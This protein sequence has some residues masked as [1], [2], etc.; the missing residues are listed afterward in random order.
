MSEVNA[1][2]LRITD[3]ATDAAKSLD[4]LASSLNKIRNALSNNLKLEQV[5][6][7]LG[8]FSTALAQS[9]SGDKVNK[10]NAI[11][12]A[13]HKLANATERLKGAGV[14]FQQAM[15][16]VDNVKANVAARVA[17]TPGVKSGGMA[18]SKPTVQSE[19][20][21]SV[22]DAAQKTREI[23]DNLKEA[24]VTAADIKIE[25]VPPKE[26]KALTDA[27]QALGRIER[28][29][30]S[31]NMTNRMYQDR[32]APLGTPENGMIGAAAALERRGFTPKSTPSQAPQGLSMKAEQ[33]KEMADALEKAKQAAQMMAANEAVKTLT[34]ARTQADLLNMK[35]DAAKQKLATGIATGKMDQTQIAT[36]AAQI[37]NMQGKLDGL[38][39]K[40]QEAADAAA[41]QATFFGRL[42]AAAKNAGETLNQAK[43]NLKNLAGAFFNANGG[44]LSLLHGMMRMAKYRIFR[45]IIREISEGFKTGL[46]NVRNYSKAINGSYA[47]DMAALDNSLLKM[48]NS[49]GAALAPAIQALVPIIQTVVSWFITAINYVNQ[50][51]ALLRGQST[52]TKAVDVTAADFEK[53]TKGASS[54]I[55]NLLADWDELN[56]IQSKGG[57]GG[58]AAED[59]SQ[60]KKMF[61]E[62]NLFDSG[63]M[64]FVEL[65]KK[66]LDDA[67]LALAG[68]IA[69]IMGFKGGTILITIG[70]VSSYLHGLKAG[71][72]DDGTFADALAG[73]IKGFI[74]AAI[75]G[76][77]I[78]WEITKTG[79]GALVGAVIGVSLALSAVALGYD[80]GSNPTIDTLGDAI[81]KNLLDMSL[82]A[83]AGGALGFFATKSV[84]GALIGLSVGAALTLTINKLFAE[85]GTGVIEQ[86]SFGSTLRNNVGTIISGASMG[87]MFGWKIG[88]GTG[89]LIGIVIGAIATLGIKYLS[90][91]KDYDENVAHWG[92][93]R[94]TADQV[95][96]WVEDKFFSKDITAKFTVV[97]TNITNTDA[98]R[99]ELQAA[100]AELSAELRM[101]MLEVDV[102]DA[103][104]KRKALVEKI[105]GEGGILSKINSTL[106]MENK[107]ITLGFSIAPMTDSDGNDITGEYIRGFVGAGTVVSD[108][109][110][111]AGKELAKLI[112][113]GMTDELSEQELTIQTKLAE[114]LE[115]TTMSQRTAQL[116]AEFMTS[117]YTLPQFTR[118]TAVEALKAYQGL[119]A[120]RRT[121]ATELYTFQ[122]SSMMQRKSTMEGQ[123]EGYKELLTLYSPESQEYKEASKYV[124]LL[125]A[126]ITEL[127]GQIEEFST[128]KAMS[129]FI[130]NIMKVST[131]QGGAVFGSQVSNAFLNAWTS[132]SEEQVSDIFREM[133]TYP[134]P[135]WDAFY[136]ARENYQNNPNA[137][138]KEAYKTAYEN[139]LDGIIGKFFGEDALPGIKELINS[140]YL[141][142]EDL[143]SQDFFKKAVSHLHFTAHGMTDPQA[144]EVG[145]KNRVQ[146][147]IDAFAIAL[148][149][150][151]PE[152]DSAYIDL[153][154]RMT[155]LWGTPSGST[156]PDVGPRAYNTPEYSEGDTG[157][158]T[159]GNGDENGDAT[160]AM[161]RAANAIEGLKDTG[162]NVTLN[163]VPTPMLAR[164]VDKSIR[165]AGGAPVLTTG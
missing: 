128:P 116:S 56:I 81:E 66:N 51:F 114:I 17:G 85:K 77:L 37:Q 90:A 46:E 50:F 138:T 2:Q 6:F 101:L 152:Y 39:Q 55:N 24:K 48:K 41:K 78:G 127:E 111:W 28:L 72:A 58:A 8:Q 73:S 45:S 156:V 161:N 4:R 15:K 26:R 163:L 1:L 22:S 43:T 69:R 147:M 74:A 136:E 148:G 54:A 133:T 119:T 159:G 64:K 61:T 18:V 160:T 150:E 94:F 145:R 3:N 27:E 12:G 19:G 40:E 92:N 25:V 134:S 87:G 35:I 104:A 47:K 143:F 36:A 162:F 155:Q 93:I 131:Q 107:T 14:G 102:N 132:M 59:L 5:A 112:S 30:R 52:W 98:A 120:S 21:A 139:F 86:A 158:S 79:S 118:D 99:A 122:L 135:L 62:D 71:M 9:T 7:G 83:I 82:G 106:E 129:G 140:G 20:D 88:G 125:T 32:Q 65:L 105:T 53:T 68:I 154:D 49:L 57:G 96:R 151:L 121:E 109:A 95:R 10:I 149:V 157:G 33:A 97:H 146:E 153:F 117:V 100:G 165:M 11:A 115:R 113:K 142:Y 126:K 75:G 80:V 130:N 91:K 123:L 34:Q 38:R 137:S 23:A 76:A 70:I 110:T 42:D 13:L 103:E 124:D 89:A 84:Q 31:V 63:V 44:L 67:K 16:A 60:Y 29:R 108:A 144:T 164:V 141:G